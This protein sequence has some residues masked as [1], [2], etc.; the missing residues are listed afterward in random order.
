MKKLIISTFALV[1]SLTGFAQ[2]WNLDNSHA[3]L[4]F[5]VSH[6]MISDV[7]GSFKKISSKITSS[8]DDFSDAVIEFTADV[9]TINTENEQ[10]DA[11]LKGAD[12]FDAAKYGTITFK[13]KSFKKVADKKYKLVGDLTMHGVT[14]SV[15]L[16]VTLNGVAIHPYTKKQVAGF[17]ITGNIK[18][19]DFGI[20]TATP[21]NVVGDEVSLT[22][23][24]EFIKE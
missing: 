14:K 21:T 15:E 13:S 5:S 6:L 2:T 10:R 19:S 4:N 22:A 3:K 1:V 8:K 9:N 20:G 11:H 18:R 7:D 17:K 23:N 12:F 16:D 24:T